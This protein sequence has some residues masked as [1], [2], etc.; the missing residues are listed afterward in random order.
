MGT[1]ALRIVEV[2]CDLSDL[3]GRREFNFGIFSTKN[4]GLDSQLDQVC[5]QKTIHQF[6]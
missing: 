5:G 6:H 3:L 1:S 2:F 4:G